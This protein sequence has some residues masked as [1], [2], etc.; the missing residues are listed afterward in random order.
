MEIPQ[1]V[2]DELILKL[3]QS[4]HSTIL[5]GG[6]N[7]KNDGDVALK[8]SRMRHRAQKEAIEDAI[9]AVFEFASENVKSRLGE[10]YSKR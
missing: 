3:H 7:G 4:K 6:T 2:I 9:A 8:S 10:S 1:S 5:L